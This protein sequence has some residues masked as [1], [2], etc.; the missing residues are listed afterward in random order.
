MKKVTSSEKKA[1]SQ[2]AN[3]QLST[4]NILDELIHS[5]PTPTATSKIDIAA[6]EQGINHYKFN[7]LISAI[8]NMDNQ[9]VVCI[10]EESGWPDWKYEPMSST[11]FTDT[12]ELAKYLQFLACQL[13][14]DTSNMQA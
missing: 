11:T 8:I 9:I 5:M 2:M 10:D 14:T 3:E 13:F 1:L 7:R 12:N 6:K 4:D